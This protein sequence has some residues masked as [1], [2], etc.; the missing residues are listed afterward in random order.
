M[1]W[2]SGDELKVNLQAAVFGLIRPHQYG[3]REERVFACGAGSL[4]AEKMLPYVEIKW[5]SCGS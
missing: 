3:S 1:Y 5:A 4:H 2:Q